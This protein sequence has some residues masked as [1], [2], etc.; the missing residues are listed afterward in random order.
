M[1]DYPCCLK[2]LEQIFHYVSYD[3]DLVA[4]N[5]LLIRM[6]NDKRMSEDA[7]DTALSI[8]D[9]L[10]EKITFNHDESTTTS[11]VQQTKSLLGSLST[12]DILSMK[13]MDCERLLAVM[14]ILH[15]MLY[16]CYFSNNPSHLTH[17]STRMIQLTLQHGLSKYA[18]LSISAFAISLSGM[19]DKTSYDLAQLSMNLVEKLNLKDMIPFVEGAYYSIIDPLFVNVNGK[20]IIL[21][22]NN[23]LINMF[24]NLRFDHTFDENDSYL[25]RNRI[26]LL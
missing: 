17:I 21:A 11:L 5:L 12:D 19:R 18:C 13:A 15:T 25:S 3:L 6:Y 16:S 26:T 10:G 14:E 7:I 24:F 2:Y 9:K 20:H 22:D 23:E 1:V 4:P 8:L